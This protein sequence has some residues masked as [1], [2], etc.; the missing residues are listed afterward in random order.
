ML[1]RCSQC[2]YA[3]HVE[4][5]ATKPRVVCARCA[6]IISVEFLSNHSVPPLSDLF[7]KGH[8]QSE[9]L[10][11]K[12]PESPLDLDSLL[13]PSPETVTDQPISPVSPKPSSVFDSP[14]LETPS[15]ISENRW[16]GE[17]I[18]DIPRASSLSEQPTESP[19]AIEDLL[20]EPSSQEDILE[21]YAAQSSAETGLAE[22]P[23]RPGAV[24]AGA[25]E[26]ALTPATAEVSQ[27]AETIPAETSGNVP[28]AV[29]EEAAPKTTA[30]LPPKSSV[31]AQDSYLRN[32]SNTYVMATPEQGNKGRLAKVFL[33]AALVFGLLGIG[34]FALSGLVKDWLGAR[35]QVA[36]GSPL[37]TASRSG[38]N[39]GVPVASQS[40]TATSSPITASPSPSVAASASPTA[41]L[42]ASPSPAATPGNASSGTSQSAAN[43]PTPTPA[44]ATGSSGHS[45]GATD[46]S[47]AIQIASFKSAGDAQQSVA[48]LKS[49]GV[50]AR[51]VKADVPGMGIR[52]RVQTGRFTNETEAAKYA[53]ELRAKGVARDFIVTGYQNQ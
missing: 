32:A 37:P 28:D 8:H 14:V 48:R 33:A 5:D 13:S 6:T 22:E 47:L 53:G 4:A 31:F 50:E 19:L 12:T 42:K 45:V 27:E 10:F 36:T 21:S 39:A 2:Q 23:E 25:Y 3:N 35:K 24:G 1:I 34:Y 7:E 43:K 18:L 29:L 9:P 40:T 52:F 51:V 38:T 15:Q 41:S 30:P 26:N 46:G 16:D 11:M 17:E 49:A 44:T 20:S